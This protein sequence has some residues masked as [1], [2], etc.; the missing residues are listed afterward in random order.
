MAAH[1][2]SH[3]ISRKRKPYLIN[4]AWDETG[5][6]CPLVEDQRKGAAKRWGCLNGRKPN[7]PYTAALCETEQALHLVVRDSFLYLKHRSVER[8]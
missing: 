7:H 6:I 5:N 4:S 1:I 8:R 2:I 3:R